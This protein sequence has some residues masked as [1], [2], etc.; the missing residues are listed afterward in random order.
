M[1]SP[2]CCNVELDP[3]S[4]AQGEVTLLVTLSKFHLHLQ[5]T[6]SMR[7][8]KKYIYIYI[9]TKTLANSIL[10]KAKANV[11]TTTE[12]GISTTNAEQHTSERS[13]PL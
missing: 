12:E 4:M 5:N 8:G 1:I 6:K 2:I 9:Q 11:Y 13:F 7:E 3:V 10:R